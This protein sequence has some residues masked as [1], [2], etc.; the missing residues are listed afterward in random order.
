MVALAIAAVFTAAIVGHRAKDTRLQDARVD[1]WL[2]GHRGERCDATSPS[3]IESAWN[4]R[5]IAYEAALV[6]LAGAGVVAHRR[7]AAHRSDGSAHPSGE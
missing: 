4:R 7:A 6:V 5:E 1:H 3:A 2:C